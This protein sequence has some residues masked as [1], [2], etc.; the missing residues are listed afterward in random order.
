[1]NFYLLKKRE[2]RAFYLCPAQISQLIIVDASRVFT[3]R[4]IFFVIFF[5]KSPFVTK[6]KLLILIVCLIT[7]LNSSSSNLERTKFLI[8]VVTI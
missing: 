7:T 6:K 4:L 2:F 3:A 1:M 8:E 5:A